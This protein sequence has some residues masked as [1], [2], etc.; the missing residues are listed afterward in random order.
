MSDF[1]R[2]LWEHLKSL[3][4][5]GRVFW[6]G[7]AMIDGGDVEDYFETELVRAEDFIKEHE[8]SQFLN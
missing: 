5:A 1:E 3:A 2:K 6:D 4:D 7:G 8:D